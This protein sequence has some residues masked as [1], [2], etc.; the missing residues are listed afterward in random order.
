MMNIKVYQ[1][2]LKFLLIDA[3]QKLFNGDVE[4]EN[5]LDHGVLATVKIDKVLDDDDINKIK[6]FMKKLVEKNIP[7]NKKNI[8]KKDGSAVFFYKFIIV[9]YAV[10]MRR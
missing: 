4:F 8:S 9:F 7:F 6:E 1:S 2:G 5:S 10:V 3:V